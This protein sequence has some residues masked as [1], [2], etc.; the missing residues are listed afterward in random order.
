MPWE[1]LPLIPMG[2]IAGL[3]AGLLGIGGGLVF[4]PLLLGLGL[5]PHQALATSTL[6]ILPT[7]FAGSWTHLRNGSLP[8]GG[9]AA[10]GAG[11]LAG[12]LLFSHLGSGL[13]GWLLLGLQSL[14]YLVLSLV[15]EPRN[16]LPGQDAMAAPLLPL[17]PLAL[18]GLVAGCASG[19]LGVGGGLV[20]VPLMV[21]GLAVRVY[22]AI[23]LSTLAVFA[24]A[25]VSAPTFLADGRGNL[26]MALVLGIS[27]GL[28][29]GW[30]A[31]RLQ[32]VSEARL[33]WLVRLF[34]L[35]LAID[36]GRRAIGLVLVHPVG[37]GA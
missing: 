35:L 11:A 32:R 37:I 3:L 24:S 15:I 8:L 23:R 29:A 26:V 10:I 36:A 31:Q 6:A 9:A 14:M 27:A 21:R 34:C 13:E 2:I 20:M 17:G 4:S 25:A 22:T 7:T 5:P 16:P 30:S 18:V 19:M 28:G 33:V 12:G 1:L